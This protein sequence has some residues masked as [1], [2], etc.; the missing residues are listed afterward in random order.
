MSALR[1]LSHSC[2]LQE[3]QAFLASCEPRIA[4]Q[5]F[6][7][8]GNKRH[9]DLYEELNG[10][11]IDIYQDQDTGIAR[12]RAKNVKGI[13]RNPAMDAVLVE[14]SRT[15]L[16][17]NTIPN[18]EGELPLEVFSFSE[19]LH[20]L[21]KPLD[22]LLRGMREELKVKTEVLSR[23]RIQRTG[24]VTKHIRR[25][26]AYAG[27]ESEVQT[28]WFVIETVLLSPGIMIPF[29]RD[30]GVTINRRWYVN[31]KPFVAP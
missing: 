31:D 17:G 5:D 19:T 11:E 12:R 8:V 4:I 27:M 16:N 10:R 29:T 6:D 30:S 3:M 26:K 24:L 23:K 21:E 2:S 20:Y 18:F 13:I 9:V 28:Y 1:T 15:Y 22:G 7:K 14:T 25:S